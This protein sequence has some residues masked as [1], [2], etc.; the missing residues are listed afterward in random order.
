[1]ACSWS[2]SKFEG[3][4]PGDRVLVRCFVPPD[5]MR[6]SDAEITA[7]AREMMAAAIGV[8]AEPELVEISRWD[9]ANLVYA[10]GHDERVKEIE[11]RRAK[12]PRLFLAGAGYRGLGLPD[13]I[14]DGRTIARSA[15]SPG[16]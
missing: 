6:S 8:T 3:R 1:M 13:C 10:V 14:S 11:A 16:P 9:G 5:G 4:S 12:H 15:L 7:R 2:S